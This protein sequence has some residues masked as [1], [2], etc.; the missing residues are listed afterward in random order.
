MP[1]LTRDRDPI[2]VALDVHKDSITAGVLQPQASS[3]VLQRIGPDDAAVRRLLGK[4]GEPGRI[5]VCYE[6][7]PTGFGLARSL[8]AGGVQCEVIAPSLVPKASGDKV[9][10]DRRDAAE[11][12]VLFRAGL[13]T[14]VHLPPPSIEAVRDLAR[15]RADVK[16]DLHRAQRRLLSFCLRH[17]H[18]YR[19][20][21][22]WTGK[23][24][25]WLAAQR[26]EQPAAQRTFEHYR[27]LVRVRQ[28]E[29]AAICE[30]LHGWLRDEEV[31]A[32]A[33]RLAAYHAIGY[34]GALSIVAE[35]GGQWDRFGTARGFMAFTG[36]VPGEHSSGR[37]EHRTGITKTG[38]K[39]LRTQLIESA[40]HYRTRPV[41]GATLAERRSHVGPATVARAVTA[42]RRLAG[43][44]RRLAARGMNPNLVTTAV[45]R[46]LAGFVWA[47]LTAN[48]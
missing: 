25:S 38:N 43:R 3:P 35:V 16:D 7:G 12:A 5:K 44:Y 36:L 20:G 8:R 18:I 22:H 39:V 4:L 27:A 19:D 29:L 33:H 40:W 21:A 11:L 41:P 32:Q 42:H 13:L 48:D 26:F 9:K 30:D 6:A 2:Y 37:R 28:G 14:G 23:H 34:L 47:E 1:I 17:G 10:T 24:E 31:G 45:A 15:A 46:E